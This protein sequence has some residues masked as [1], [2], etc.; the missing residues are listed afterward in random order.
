MKLWLVESEVA[1]LIN[2]VPSHLV[3]LN[4]LA[5]QELEDTLELMVQLEATLA[6]IPEDMGELLEDIPI[7]VVIPVT[8]EDTLVDI[9]EELPQEATSTMVLITEQ[10]LRKS[11]LN[12]ESNI[13]HLK[14]NILN[15]IEFKESKE[16]LL[17]DKLLNIKS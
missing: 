7:L 4:T 17:K 2:M 6:D 9:V 8:L 1:T 3:I 11:L 15:M 5:D 13:F 16:F 10:L 14:K 12:L